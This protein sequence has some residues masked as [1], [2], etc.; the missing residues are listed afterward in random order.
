VIKDQSRT[1]MLACDPTSLK[2][3]PQIFKQMKREAADILRAEGFGY[4]KQRHERSLAMRYRGQSFELE[5]TQTS[6]TIV[7]AFHRAHRERYGYAQEQS[8]V[9]IVSARLRSFG[10]VE[11]LH[12][13]LIASR[14]RQR[15]AKP[16][17]QATAY[18]SGRRTQL[19]V[20]R[21]EVCWVELDCGRR[22][23]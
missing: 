11:Q 20:Y 7:E 23:S 9:E 8:Q 2:T 17:K 5:V 13:A 6:G 19:G 18:L 4:R 16:H 12:E 3:L 21:R 14:A 15:T 10:L 1:V 22:A